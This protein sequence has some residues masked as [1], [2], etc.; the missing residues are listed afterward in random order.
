GSRGS[1][2]SYPPLAGHG[3]HSCHCKNTSALA[4]PSPRE[5]SVL[6]LGES[7]LPSAVA[8]LSCVLADYARTSPSPP[9]TTQANTPSTLPP[10]AYPWPLSHLENLTVCERAGVGTA[11]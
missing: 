5:L 4:Y 1:S 8:L 6:R 2:V 3:S 11:S 9:D 10:A 7:V